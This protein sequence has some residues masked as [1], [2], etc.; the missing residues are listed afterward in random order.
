MTFLEFRRGLK[1]FKIF[2][3]S[4]IR[5]IDPGFYRTRLNEWQNKGYIR[6]VIRGY[7]IFTEQE[8]DEFSLFTFANK[9]YNPSY[10]SLESA[11]SYYHLIPQSVYAVTSVTTLPTRVFKTSLANFKYHRIKTAM[12][13]GYELMLP[14]NKHCKIACPEKALLDYFYINPD[15]KDCDDFAQLRVNTD[16]FMKQVNLEKLDVLVERIGQKALLRRINA[17][18]EYMRNA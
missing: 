10:I 5:G 8:L 16:E 18:K 7:Y 11:L 6:K 14:N 2:S 4:D 12:F 15:I 17:F 13:F 3:L 9:I 1:D